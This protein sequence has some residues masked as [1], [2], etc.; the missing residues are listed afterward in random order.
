[1]I[2]I[3]KILQEKYVPQVRMNVEGVEYSEVLRAI[4]FGG[5]QLTEDRAISAQKALSDGD[6][7]FERLGGLQPKFEDWHLKAMLYEVISILAIII[8]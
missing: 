6:T 7:I 3:L 5:D 2:Q 8:R 1:M 4:S